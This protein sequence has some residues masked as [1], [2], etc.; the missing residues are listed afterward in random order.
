[1]DKSLYLLPISTFKSIFLF[2]KVGSYCTIKSLIESSEKEIESDSY[3]RVAAIYDHEEVGSESATG[4]A[5]ALTEHILRRLSNAEKFELAVSK[6]F[7]ISC[8]QAHAVHPN[9]S[10]YHEENHR[11]SLH[12]GVVL[13]YNGNQRFEYN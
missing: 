8:D 2:F 1:M 5:S 6:S 4:A 11:P 3:V 10:E 13:K 9:Y 7:L 12:G